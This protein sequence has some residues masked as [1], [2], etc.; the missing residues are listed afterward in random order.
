MAK[1]EVNT[2]MLQRA[3][4]IRE[5]ITYLIHA[6]EGTDLTPELAQARKS[7]EAVERVIVGRLYP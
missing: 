4:N 6:C 5:C 7:M 2:Y 1:K 3:I